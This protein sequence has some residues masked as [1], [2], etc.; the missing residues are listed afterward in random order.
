MQASGHQDCQTD[1]AV[2]GGIMNEGVVNWPTSNTPAS[3]SRSVGVVKKR[4]PELS[5]I[6]SRRFALL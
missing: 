3:Y 2:R 6:C 1:A 5:T 4:K